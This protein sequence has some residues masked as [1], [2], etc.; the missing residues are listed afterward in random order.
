MP[1]IT[2][3]KSL[4]KNHENFAEEEYQKNEPLLEITVNISTQ[5]EEICIPST[6]E[7]RSRLVRI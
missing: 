6:L 4:V 1:N 7:W 5:L 2:K 3:I